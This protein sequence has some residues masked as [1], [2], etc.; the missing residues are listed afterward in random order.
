MQGTVTEEEVIGPNGTTTR[1]I[2]IGN[3]VVRGE[4]TGF[5]VRP[6]SNEGSV[7]RPAQNR[8]YV[9]NDRDYQNLLD[10]LR[11]EAEEEEERKQ[12]QRNFVP[13]DMSAEEI[14]RLFEVAATE[15]T[16]KHDSTA[17]VEDD[18]EGPVD[19]P[20]C[21]DSMDEDVGKS[22][23]QCKHKFHTKCLGQWMSQQGDNNS[24]C[25]ICRSPILKTLQL[26]PKVKPVE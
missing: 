19:C 14:E 2:R 9:E 26:K 7:S 22:M 16:I 23:P 3:L 13:D 10:L 18:E 25:P 4:V 20:I 1:T 5:R 21:L 11:R 6:G 24:K 15:A 8:D 17:D 12:A